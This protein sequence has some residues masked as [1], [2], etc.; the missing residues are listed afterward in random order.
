MR[1]AGYRHQQVSQLSATC[2]IPPEVGSGQPFL[3]LLRPITCTFTVFDVDGL[4]ALESVGM[5]T[6]DTS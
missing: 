2:F 1:R 4:N 3:L 6:A 5:K